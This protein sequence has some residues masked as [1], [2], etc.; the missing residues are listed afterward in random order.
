[1][2]AALHNG[3]PITMGTDIGGQDLLPHGRNAAE[4]ALLVR[5]GMSPTDALVAGTSGAA[6]CLGLDAER[7][8]LEDG[9]VADIIAVPGD[10]VQD[11]GVM[12]RVAFVMQNGQV[13]KN[14]P[15]IAA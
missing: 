8:S 6:R 9:K 2:E 5:F 13:V 12:E 10:P 3:V 7:G 11:I 15:G 1:M 14:S 4:L